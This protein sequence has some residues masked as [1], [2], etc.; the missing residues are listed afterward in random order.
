MIRIMIHVVDE[1]K[2]VSESLKGLLQRGKRMEKV[3]LTESQL[4]LI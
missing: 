1:L 2:N 4:L 3:D